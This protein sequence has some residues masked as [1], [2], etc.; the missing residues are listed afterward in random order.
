ML[1]TNIDIV[2]RLINDQISR[3]ELVDVKFGLPQGSI[4]GPVLFNI[5]VSDLQ[6][7][8]NA[9]CYQYADD[10]SL[11]LPLQGV[12]PRQLQSH[13]DK[14]YVQ[15]G[16]LVASEQSSHLNSLKTKLILFS[17]AQLARVHNLDCT[18]LDV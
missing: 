10:T 5:C 15:H 4:L 17:T 1:T 14:R 7:Q 2:D 18:P 9:K 13:N 12:G 16:P 11:Y 8:I 3:T 6:D